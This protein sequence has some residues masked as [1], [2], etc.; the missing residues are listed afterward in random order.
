MKQML[1]FIVKVILMLVVIKLLHT[2]ISS[3]L[4]Y[5]LYLECRRKGLVTAVKTFLEKKALFLRP[6]IFQVFEYHL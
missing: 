6:N 1:S 5:G 4:T 2:I 3:W